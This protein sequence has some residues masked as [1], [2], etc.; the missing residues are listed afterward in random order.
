MATNGTQIIIE[1]IHYKEV[2]K[3]FVLQRI[4]KYMV[5]NFHH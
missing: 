2:E 1:N 4:T 3:V 5:E